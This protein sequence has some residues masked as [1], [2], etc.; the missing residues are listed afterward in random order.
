[1]RR[2]LNKSLAYFQLI[3]VTLFN[4]FSLLGL[5]INYWRVLQR[6][7]C[8]QVC[9]IIKMNFLERCDTRNLFCIHSCGKR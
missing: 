9:Q 5:Q 2:G 4:Q 7:V 3:F 6:Q 8:K 1:M